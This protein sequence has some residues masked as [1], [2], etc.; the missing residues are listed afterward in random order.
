MLTTPVAVFIFKRADK[1]VSI[2]QAVAKAQPQKL[3]IVSDAGRDEAEKAIVEQCR[4][5]VENAVSWPCEVVRLYEEENQGCHN[6][7]MAALKIFE[8]E[9]TCIFLEDDNYPEETFFEYCQTML[10][11]YRNNEDILWVC[12][13]N[14]MTEST[15]PFDYDCIMT[16]HML[17]CGWASWATKFQKYY[18]YDFRDL[19]PQ[20]ILQAKQSYHSIDCSNTTK[21][22]GRA[23]FGI[24]RTVGMPLGT[25]I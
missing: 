5:A 6:I 1:S 19:T 4:A 21:R 17:P 7:G 3:Y 20:G 16:Q 11:K 14:Y 2:I 25:T 18:E 10:E 8:K 13:T 23:K 12:G 24:N 22:I 9:E 15:F